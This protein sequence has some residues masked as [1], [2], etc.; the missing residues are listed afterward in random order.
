M[1]GSFYLYRIVVTELIARRN[2]EL[3]SNVNYPHKP[4][5]DFFLSESVHD[6][7]F[8]VANNSRKNKHQKRNHLL[9]KSG[10]WSPI[11]V[12]HHLST[13]KHKSKTE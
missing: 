2:T 10:K 8:A 12:K 5:N 4:F 13:E 7:S 9:I 3:E 11:F 1:V 6:V